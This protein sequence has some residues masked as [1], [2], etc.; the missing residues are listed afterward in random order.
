MFEAFD[1]DSITVPSCNAHNTDKNLDDQAVIAFFMQGLYYVLARGSVSPN[2]LRAMV[3]SFEKVAETRGI[4]LRPLIE[5][6]DDL[7]F[8]MSHIESA[9]VIKAWIRQLTAAICWSAVGNHVPDVDWAAAPLF[10]PNF[11]LGDDPRTLDEAAD[12]IQRVRWLIASES[13]AAVHWWRGWSAY[14]KAYPPDI[15]RFELSFLPGRYLVDPN[16][17]NQFLLRH[18]FYGEFSWS[19]LVD[20]SADLKTSLQRFVRDS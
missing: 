5:G 1:S 12:E 13:R 4:D 18:W 6:H 19:V 20:G 7:S 11:H 15:Y 3:A 8:P 14:P 16:S 17:R 10:S 2:S 9:Q